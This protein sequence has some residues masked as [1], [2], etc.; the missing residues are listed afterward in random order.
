MGST[1]QPEAEVGGDLIVAAAGG[2]ELSTDRADALGQGVLDVHVDIFERLD[3][4]EAAGDDVGAD[5]LQAGPN[6]LD[7]GAGQDALF[8]QHGSVGERALDILESQRLIDVY[9][10]VEALHQGG[11]LLPKPTSPHS[12]TRGH[13]VGFVVAH[14]AGSSCVC[15]VP[16][17]FLAKVNV[18]P[19]CSA[20][21]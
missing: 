9:R 19:C 17:T 13:S 4:D 2:V 7:L 14:G 21:R 10:G 8:A 6:R 1:S 3:P 5:V 11:G 20:T 16:P 18:S 15:Q 12:F